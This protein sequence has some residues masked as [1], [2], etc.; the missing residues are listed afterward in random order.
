MIKYMLNIKE[1]NMVKNITDKEFEHLLSSSQKPI[2]VDFWAQWCGPCRQLG[3]VVDELA[4]EMTEVE[5]VKINIDDNPDTPSKFGVRGIPT[6]I[7][8]N[9]GKQK[10]VK[11]GALPKS[12]LKEWIDSNI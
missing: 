3:P 9:D 7:L 5:F 10:A 11:V 6:L 4:E 1:I 2:V 8:F 12:A